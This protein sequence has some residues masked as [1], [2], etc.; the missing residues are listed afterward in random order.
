MIALLLDLHNMYEVLEVFIS[1]GNTC[2]QQLKALYEMLEIDT[3]GMP[4]NWQIK[5]LRPDTNLPQKILF[6]WDRVYGDSIFGKKK[7]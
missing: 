3:T 7:S 5:T 1:F 6:F 4:E 2:L